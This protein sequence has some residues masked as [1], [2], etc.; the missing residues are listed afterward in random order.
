MESL[1]SATS[2]YGIKHA[3]KRHL[4]LGLDSLHP[5]VSLIRSQVRIW[6]AEELHFAVRQCIYTFKHTTRLYALV[7]T[8]IY[9]SLYRI[10][11]DTQL[12]Y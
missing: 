9:A 11:R 12:F 7:G 2:L 6:E 3:S 8:H 4:L 1:G 5:F 10:S